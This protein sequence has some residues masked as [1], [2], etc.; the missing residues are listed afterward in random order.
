[1]NIAGSLVL[2]EEVGGGDMNSITSA[3]RLYSIIKPVMPGAWWYHRRRNS[4]YEPYG[5]MEGLRQRANME[6]GR[7]NMN[8]VGC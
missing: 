6:V 8:I 4:L 1:M 5:Y 3:V 2:E 7:H